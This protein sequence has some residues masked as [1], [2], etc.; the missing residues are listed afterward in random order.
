MNFQDLKFIVSSI[1]EI[2]NI[3]WV[4]CLNQLI[5]NMGPGDY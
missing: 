3:K 1:T 4:S 5:L 2:K